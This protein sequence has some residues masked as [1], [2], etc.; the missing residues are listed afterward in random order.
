MTASIPIYHRVLDATTWHE[1]YD[2]DRDALE[3]VADLPLPDLL[4]APPR[5]PG[6][7]VAVEEAILDEWVGNCLAYAW[8]Q[9]NHVDGSEWIADHKIRSLSVG[10]V[11]VLGEQAYACDPVGWSPTRMG[12][13]QQQPTTPK[14]GDK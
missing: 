9:M 2:P 14:E 4:S 5:A 1:P 8:R 6:W 12:R 7:A 10:D 13:V 11:V 3:K